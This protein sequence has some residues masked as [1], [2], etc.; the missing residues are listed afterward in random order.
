MADDLSFCG[1][2]GRALP[3]FLSLTYREVS[4]IF[5]WV[6]WWFPE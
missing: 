3:H 2:T 6:V 1:L 5:G 4:W